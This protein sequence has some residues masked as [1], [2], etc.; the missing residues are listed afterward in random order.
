MAEQEMKWCAD[1]QR[2]IV[3]HGYAAHLAGKKHAAVVAGKSEEASHGRETLPQ[4][5]PRE[6]LEELGQ[7]L[8]EGLDAEEGKLASTAE[9]EYGRGEGVEL[10][11]PDPALVD[12][13][14]AGLIPGTG[15]DPGGELGSS[16]AFGAG[17]APGHAAG[18][19]GE[20][21]PRAAGLRGPASPGGEPQQLGSHP[22]LVSDLA[23]TWPRWESYSKITNASRTVVMVAAACQIPVAVKEGNI[24]GTEYTTGPCQMAVRRNKN[25]E[26]SWFKTCDHGP[27]RDQKGREIPVRLRPYL[28]GNI[29]VDRRPHITES[30]VV[31]GWDET[32]KWVVRARLQKV[33]VDKVNMSGEAMRYHLERGWLRG[34]A[35]GI[36]DVCQMMDCW[37][38]GSFIPFARGVFCSVGHARLVVANERGIILPASAMFSVETDWPR[39]PNADTW[40]ERLAPI[41]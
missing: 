10:L 19:G 41:G 13:I 6:V 23:L 32:P 33:V 11:E 21:G 24:M 22:H 27:E 8:R 5:V 7:E 28:E 3:A 38:K 2:E 31:D 26:F 39:Q 12:P 16:P 25:L 18:L 15:S 40:A 35:F 36:N 9:Y 17:Q 20:G 37:A 14:V 1:C 30:G 34:S 29:V 4:P